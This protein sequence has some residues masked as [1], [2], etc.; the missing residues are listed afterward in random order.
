MADTIDEYDINRLAE[1]I[2]VEIRSLPVRNV[3][4][5]RAVRRKYSNMLKKSEPEIILKLGRK[6]FKTYGYR[7]VAYE[8]D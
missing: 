8:L 6:I 3:P 7:W 1:G 4:N 5:I 2:D